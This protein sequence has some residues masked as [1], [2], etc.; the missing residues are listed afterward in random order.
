MQKLVFDANQ[1][2]SSSSDAC[3][4]SCTWASRGGFHLCV[5]CFLPSLS[6]RLCDWV[7]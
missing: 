7:L 5:R 1:M 2:E 4:T 6:T 3:G